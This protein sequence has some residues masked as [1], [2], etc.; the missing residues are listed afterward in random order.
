M[1]MCLCNIF[2]AAGYTDEYCSKYIDYSPSPCNYLCRLGS[3][4]V[5]CGTPDIVI[6]SIVIVSTH[7]RILGM[8]TVVCVPVKIL[9]VSSI[10]LHHL[11]QHI[12][13]P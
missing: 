10:S 5:V 3:V 8:A 2:Q 1:F 9:C 7:R 11:N 4:Y 13:L 6:A 12:N